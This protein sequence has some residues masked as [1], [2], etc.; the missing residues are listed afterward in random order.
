MCIIAR[1][2]ACIEICIINK[3]L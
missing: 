3:T 1:N 2:P